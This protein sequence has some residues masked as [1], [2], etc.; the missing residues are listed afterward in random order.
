MLTSLEVNCL[1]ICRAYYLK[2]SFGKNFLWGSKYQELLACNAIIFQ[3]L[4]RLLIVFIFLFK[5][6]LFRNLCTNTVSLL[7]CK[8]RMPTLVK[9]AIKK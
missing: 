4:N 8:I 5:K 1:I 3:I 2:I 9:N 7:F 6:I